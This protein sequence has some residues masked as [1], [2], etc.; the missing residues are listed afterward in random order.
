VAAHP[1]CRT[2]A[3]AGILAALC[4]FP[5][6]V[7]AARIGD[8]GEASSISEQAVRFFTFADPALRCALLGALLLGLNCGLLGSFIVVRR[9]ALVGDTL[10]H[11]VLPG[12]ALGFLWASSKDPVAILVGA[13][14]VGMAGVLVSHAIE[15]TTRLKQDSALGIVLASFYAIGICLVDHIQRSSAGKMSGIKSFLFGQ[16]SAL[17]EADVLLMAVISAVSLL[18]ITLLR[19]SLVTACF[20]SAFAHAIGL[21][22]RALERL[23]LLLTAVAVVVA[24]QAAGVVLVSALLVIPASTAYLLADRMPRMLVIAALVGMLSAASG[25]FFSFLGNHLP[26][27]PLIV[28]SAACFFVVAFLFAPR[29]GW[30][31]GVFMRRS[32]WRR[33]RRE[34][35]LKTFYKVLEDRQFDGEDIA[36]LTVAQ[37]RKESVDEVVRRV[38][39]LVAHGMVTLGDEGETAYFTPEGLREAAR[40]VRNHR[41]WELYLTTVADYPADHVHEDAE[42]IEHVLGADMVRQLERRLSFPTE[43]PHGKPI[44]V[45]P[46]PVVGAAGFGIA[47]ETT[48][49]RD[50]FRL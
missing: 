6:A 31:S 40:I 20:D 41:L 47:G 37:I 7:W 38:R 33:T 25:A 12:I 46:E 14:L 9:M 30:L 32:R 35:T 28:L 45:V 43:D 48:E 19:G 24:M 4:F 22:V 36:L 16:A 10:S 21:P 49:H 2:V 18:V 3:P 34:N 44:P 42:E 15:R 23:L 26:T 17:S 8:V 1:V 13:T 50:R 27:G 39:D 29:H 5:V 11:A